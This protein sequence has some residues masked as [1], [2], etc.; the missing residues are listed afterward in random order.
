MWISPTVDYVIGKSVIYPML[1]SNCL[2]TCYDRSVDKIDG[3]A[4]KLT[5]K[6]AGHQS[7]S[8]LP[9]H[10]FFVANPK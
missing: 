9:A 10:N 5:R 4:Q 2:E 8:L 6:Q 1:K 7:L 3:E